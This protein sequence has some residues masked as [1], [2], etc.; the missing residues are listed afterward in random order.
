[1]REATS[2]H[3]FDK[4]V[5]PRGNCLYC[6]RSI[7]N[8]LKECRRLSSRYLDSKTKDSSYYFMKKRNRSDLVINKEQSSINNRFIS[9]KSKTRGDTEPYRKLDRHV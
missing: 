4:S 7:P 8:R 6:D 9:I 2:T 1:M 3:K 5:S